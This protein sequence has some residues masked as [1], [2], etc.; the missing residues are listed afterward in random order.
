[1]RSG[2]PA[3]ASVSARTTIRRA[4]SILKPLS[5]E[6]LASASAA[7]AARW[8]SARIGARAD[9]DRF[10]FTGPPRFQRHAAERERALSTIVSSSMRSAAAA[11]TTAKGVGGA[12]ANFQIAGMGGEMRRLGRQAHRDDHLAG[13]QAR[14][15]GPACRPAGGETFR[16]GSPAGRLCL[17]SRQRRRARQEARRNRTG[18]S[19]CSSRSIP[20]WR[21]A[22]CRRRG[23]R[24]PNRGRAY[25]RRW[26]RRRNRRS[27]SAAGD[28]R[29]PS[30]R[31]EAAPR[32]RTEAPR[33]PPESAGRKCDRE[34]DRHCGPARRS[35]RCRRKGP[36]C[37]RGRE[38]G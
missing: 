27:A 24:S 9:Q 20:V 35:A 23:R 16:A 3:A 34:R 33:R 19:R 21:E 7:S 1:M 38:G 5:P 4:S 12:L 15:R 11:E 6:G 2:V 26:R 31:C 22:C 37:G 10:R 32:R 18:A 13:L 30:R 25:C 28:C 8:N 29:R 36:R 17:R 14:S